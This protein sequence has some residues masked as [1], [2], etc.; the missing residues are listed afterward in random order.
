MRHLLSQGHFPVELR[1]SQ[2][3][4]E[5]IDSRTTAAS[6]TTCGIGPILL[7][8]GD[9][10]VSSYLG[11]E[12]PKSRIIGN[13]GSISRCRNHTDNDCTGSCTSD[14][15]PT[16]PLSR[17]LTGKYMPECNLFPPTAQFRTSTKVV[18]TGGDECAIGQHVV[19][20]YSHSRTPFVGIVREILQ[21]IGTDAELVHEPS[22]V[23]IQMVDISS[24]EGR[25]RLPQI[26]PCDE[27]HLISYTVS[28]L[29]LLQT[30]ADS[31]QEYSLCG[32]HTA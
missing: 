3:N 30:R 16:R 18:I 24:I 17:C 28:E 7:I 27:Y 1:D 20:H 21:Q 6:I 14:K 19:F 12:K 11:L 13:L 32:K 31:I 8:A 15:G 22:A 25:F 23:L 10:T 5:P 4:K 9:A 29:C 2:P 26:K